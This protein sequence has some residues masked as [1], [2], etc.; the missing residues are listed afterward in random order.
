M[1]WIIENWFL[2]VS[3]L[4]L[5]F[6][7]GIAIYKFAGLPTE[8]QVDK[9]KEWLVWACIEAERELQSGT[10]QLKL[11]QVYNAFC[12]VPTFTAV[13]KFISFDLF[14][15]W[16]KDA[17]SKAKRM[18]ATN[19]NLAKYVYGDFADEEIKKL[20]EQLEQCDNG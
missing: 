13:A 18:L 6:M 14:D 15:E 4:A 19:T 20:K 17:L 16:V 9:I 2:I 1:N 10:G 5:L 8:Q 11:R 3:G 12:A 7:V